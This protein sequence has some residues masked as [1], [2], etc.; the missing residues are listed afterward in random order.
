MVGSRG[1]GDGE[2]VVVLGGDGDGSC[3]T[4]LSGAV[5]EGGGSLSGV[6]SDATTREAGTRD[7]RP[8]LG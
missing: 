6:E 7:H 5:E 1:S 3:G 2:R 8:D 4:T